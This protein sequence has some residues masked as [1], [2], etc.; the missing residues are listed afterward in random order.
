M[1]FHFRCYAGYLGYFIKNSAKKCHHN[2]YTYSNYILD[3]NMCFEICVQVE[4]AYVPEE[5]SAAERHELVE[6]VRQKVA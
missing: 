2:I 6:S 1:I 4:R 5:M 3:W